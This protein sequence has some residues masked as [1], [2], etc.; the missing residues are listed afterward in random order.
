MRGEQG[1]GTFRR[2][3][4]AVLTVVLAIAGLAVAPSA[5][6]A[7][8]TPAQSP[9][10]AGDRPAKV[11]VVLVNFPDD[12]STP[13]SVDDVRKTIFT[14]G[15]NDRWNPNDHRYANQ[16]FREASYNQ[17][18]LQGRD[19][20]LNGDILGWYTIPGLSKTQCNENLI[21]VQTRQYVEN[22]A[23]RSLAGYD[24]VI[25]ITNGSMPCWWY[26]MTFG[27]TTVINGQ[28]GWNVV[29]HEIGHALG[30]KHS[31]QLEC[32]R[33]DHS[34]ATISSSCHVATDAGTN[35]YDG[36]TPMGGGSRLYTASEKARIGWIPPAGVATVTTNGTLTLQAS[37]NAPGG[38][39]Q[40]LRIPHARDA[41]GNVTEWLEFEIRETVGAFDDFDPSDTAV[42]GVNVRL[43]GLWNS[44][45]L[46]NSWLLDATPNTPTFT[47][48]SLPAGSSVTDSMTGVTIKTVAFDSIGHTAQVQV[49]FA[50]P[51]SASN[52]QVVGGELR[53]TGAPGTSSDVLF[54]PGAAAG[55]V[56][57]HDARPVRAADSTC[58][59]LPDAGV[60]CHGVT[61]IN[62]DAG[63]LDDRITVHA[64][65]PSFVDGGDGNDDVIVDNGVADVVQCGAG[66]DD[67]SRDGSLVGDQNPA[68]DCER[69]HPAHWTAPVVAPD[70]FPRGGDLSSYG[71][72]LYETYAKAVGWSAML[73]RWDCA[74]FRC[75]ASVRDLGGHSLGRPAVLATF[76]GQD[77]AMR[78]IANR[79]YYKNNRC[80]NA[81]PCW[82]DWQD[83][84]TDSSGR[85]I[86]TS[87]DPDLVLFPN[88]GVHYALVVRGQDG[89]LWARVRCEWCAQLWTDWISAGA[90]LGA[91]LVG[92]PGGAS[93]NGQRRAELFA[94]GIDHSLYQNAIDCRDVC[95][96]TG[97]QK[98]G[99]L[100]GRHLV[101]DVDATSTADGVIDVA[102]E[103]SGRQVWTRRYRASGWDEWLDPISGRVA[104]GRAAIAA[105]GNG[106]LAFVATISNTH[107]VQ[108]TYDPANP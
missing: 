16:F 40:L 23:A 96:F 60:R 81:S 29:V 48:A 46:A 10:L 4:R 105:T 63:D 98:A 39:A 101:G 35:G 17:F 34:P 87:S 36:S 82:T 25:E 57:V 30:L 18:W 44:S 75:S 58:S 1:R 8:T 37:E 42:R 13:F 100:D 70:L 94:L 61:K 31:G 76:A 56:D 73:R 90:P 59:A 21:N 38:G 45:I 78:S 104:P 86:R 89:A 62:V 32:E 5:S 55:E 51:S 108:A 11:T 3:R 50:D 49:T 107:Q 72:A 53:F 12:T 20:P 68:G 28:P 27:D 71:G 7:S 85:M 2:A 79:V 9:A 84:S 52:A 106:R 14:G 95:A 54:T 83:V 103:T 102:V 64:P 80:A 88:D 26:G 74:D 91:R 15:G 92:G 99:P 69:V 77:V 66:S 65:V 43:F 41:S 33:A 24:Y 22:V 6:H 93:L 97:W 47:G 67:L 19:D